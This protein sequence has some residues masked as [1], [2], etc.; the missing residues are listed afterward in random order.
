MFLHVVNQRSNLRLLIILNLCRVDGKEDILFHRFY[1]HFFFRLWLFYYRSRFRLF[2]YH[3]LWFIINRSSL[4]I[5]F[6]QFNAY[7]YK[8]IQLPVTVTSF[9]G[10][11]LIRQYV[12][13][14][15]NIN[16]QTI[17]QTKITT[18]T[19]TTCRKNLTFLPKILQLISS[20]IKRIGFIVIKTTIQSCTGKDIT[21]EHPLRIKTT[22]QS[23]EISHNIHITLQIFILIVL[24]RINPSS[25]CLPSTDTNTCTECGSKLITNIKSSCRR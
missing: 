24:L 10:V 9:L 13:I 21:I 16:G 7:T 8:G 17:I 6:T 20:C 22:E 11:E 23:T 4:C 15:F 14:S 12:R 1:Y 2:H 5:A 19:E 18:K 3:R 25:F